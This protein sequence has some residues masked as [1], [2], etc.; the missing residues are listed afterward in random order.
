MTKRGRTSRQVRMLPTKFANHVTLSEE[1][2]DSVQVPRNRG[3]IW[4][5]EVA[6]SPSSGS[7]PSYLEATS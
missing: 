4:D 5:R 2:S 3:G 1:G 6:W 7:R